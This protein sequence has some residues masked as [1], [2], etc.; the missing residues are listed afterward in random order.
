MFLWVCKGNKRGIVSWGYGVLGFSYR[1]R[2]MGKVLFSQVSVCP[3]PGGYLPSG[4]QGEY[5]PSSWWGRYLPWVFLPPS[6]VGTPIKGSYPPGQGRYPLPIKGRYPPP[7]FGIPTFLHC[8]YL[9]LGGR[10]ASC[11]HAAGLSCF[12]KFKI[13]RILFLLFESFREL[14]PANRT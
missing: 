4:Q 2:R 3:H 1:I 6:K 7:K 10:Y 5:L 12:F 9:L 13:V 14:F 8:K 11:F